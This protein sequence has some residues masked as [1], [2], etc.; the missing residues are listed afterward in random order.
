MCAEHNGL[1]M[2]QSLSFIAL[3]PEVTEFLI[4]MSLVSKCA[5]FFIE[6]QMDVMLPCFVVARTYLDEKE[7]PHAEAKQLETLEISH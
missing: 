1:C 7:P 6:R 5:K 4:L 3:R 2:C